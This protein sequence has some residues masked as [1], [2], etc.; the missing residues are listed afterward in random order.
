MT[1]LINV[2]QDKLV[3]VVCIAGLVV[4]LVTGVF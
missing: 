4:C 2:D 3:M 1:K